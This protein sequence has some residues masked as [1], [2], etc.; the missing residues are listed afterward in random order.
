MNRLLIL[1]ILNMAC[2]FA[3]IAQQQ[4]A[5]LLRKSVQNLKSYRSIEVS[6]LQVSKNMLSED[7]TVI[8]NKET[9]VQNAEGQI[10]AQNQLKLTAGT[11]YYREVF[12]DGKLYSLDL[13]DSVYSITA[14]PKKVINSL[15]QYIDNITYALAKKT[16]KLSRLADT[17]I[18]G[19]PCYSI[20]ARNYDTV[21]NDSHDFTYKYFYLSKKNLLP[22]MT[23]EKGA[24]SASKGGYEIGRI[25]IYNQRYFDHYVINQE[26]APSVFA[27]NL[28]D[29]D[30]ETT[31]MLPEGAA[32][33]AIAVRQVTGAA[34]P[35][36]QFTGKVVLLQFGSV[37]CGANALANPAMNRLATRY[38][39]RNAAIACIYS[40]ETPVQAQRYIK[41][42]NIR[43]PVYL[44]SGRLKRKFQTKG[45]PNFY[46]INS[47]GVIVKSISG[48]SDD[49]E[50]ELTKAIDGLLASPPAP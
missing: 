24:G 36:G 47:Q 12:I 2:C 4:P 1:F 33:P 28:T 18:A 49:L 46:L 9:I 38:A 6:V 50:E 16:G 25:N 29:L 34:I 39:S 27:Y 32:A 48:Y 8:N 15:T 11:P 26:I 13:R 17:L 41:D 37:T 40:E 35:A 21:V 23:I 5:D 14:N 30:P 7:T 31:A 22:L 45:T 3:A 44:G 20:F 19:Q 43:F 42:N 10:T